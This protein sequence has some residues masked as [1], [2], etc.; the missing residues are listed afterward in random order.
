[1]V[2]VEI[3]RARPILGKVSLLIASNTGSLLRVPL[4]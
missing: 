4:H 2:L 1:V 3:T